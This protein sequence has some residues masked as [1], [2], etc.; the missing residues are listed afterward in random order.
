MS[1]GVNRG[2]SYVTGSS[3]MLT[4]GPKVE[5]LRGR[6]QPLQQALHQYCVQTVSYTG[7]K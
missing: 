3:G 4:Q 7:L 2:L 1:S 5:G 6:R